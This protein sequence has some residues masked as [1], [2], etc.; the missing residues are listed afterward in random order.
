LE[1]RNGLLVPSQLHY[2]WRDPR[3]Q[4]RS[5]S[6]VNIIKLDLKPDLKKADFDRSR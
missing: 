4:L 2:L 5:H 1:E 3:G 6:S